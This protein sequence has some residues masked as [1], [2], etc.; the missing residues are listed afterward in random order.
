MRDSGVSSMIKAVQL[1]ISRVSMKTPKACRRPSLAGWLMSAAAAAQGAEPLPASFE[2]R[3]RLAPFMMTAPM[4]PATAWRK[5][6]AS[7]KIRSRTAGRRP[8]L[9]IMIKSVR[10]KY[11][12]AMTGTMMSRT[13]TVA[14]F[15]RTMTAARMVR[16]TVV[17][18]GG[19]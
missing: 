17:Q 11:N 5:P 19:M 12:P 2:K 15:R 7:R 8:I 14:F 16:Q 18:M 4:P 9:R 1:Q 6:K 10:A 3:P 13:R